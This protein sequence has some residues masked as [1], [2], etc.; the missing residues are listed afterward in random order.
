[1]ISNIR[2]LILDAGA[3]I[4]LEGRDRRVAILI[5]TVRELGGMIWIPAGALAQA[6]RRGSRQARLASLLQN[7][8]VSVAELTSAR[9][10]AAGELCSERHTTDV[11]DASVVIL[12]RQV[13]GLVATSDANNL[14]IL[15][16][17]VELV[18]I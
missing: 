15:D 3:L 18:P 16:S 2:P 10:R 1:M 12:A 11:I 14:R 5:Q 8:D 4:A 17:H 9:A 13:G 7:H 6:W